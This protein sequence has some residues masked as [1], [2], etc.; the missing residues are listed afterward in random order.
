MRPL[1]DAAKNGWT[2]ADFSV[3][4]VA[5]DL[6]TQQ[7]RRTDFIL[8]WC[9]A[10][11]GWNHADWGRIVFSDESYSQL[12]PD[13]H[14]RRVWRRSG[15]RADPAF[16]IICHTEFQQGI[17]VRVAIS[18]EAGPLWSSLDAHLQHIGTSTIF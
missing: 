4:M 16:P 9:L 5:V 13:D 3:I 17:M 2:V 1:E 12:S 7:I 6:G 18:F 10:R 11:S 8:Q 15:Q 14:R